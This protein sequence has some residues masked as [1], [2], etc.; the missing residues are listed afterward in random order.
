MTR[1]H[2]KMIWAVVCSL[3]VGGIMTGMFLLLPV[4]ALVFHYGFKDRDW[5]L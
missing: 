5:K 2:K 4:A 1:T 3:F